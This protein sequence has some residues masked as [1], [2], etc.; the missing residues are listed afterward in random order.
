MPPLSRPRRLLARISASSFMRGISKITATPASSSVRK[1]PLDPDQEQQ[2]I[3]TIK[4]VNAARLCRQ[5]HFL[6]GVSEIIK[7]ELSQRICSFWKSQFSPRRIC[8]A[9]VAEEIPHTP[10]TTPVRRHAGRAAQFHREPRRA[11][12]RRLEAEEIGWFIAPARRGRPGFDLDSRPSRSKPSATGSP[13]QAGLRHGHPF[14]ELNRVMDLGF[15]RL[16][17]GDTGYL[18]ANLEPSLIQTNRH[19]VDRTADRPGWSE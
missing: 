8:A 1:K 9:L 5:A 11:A 4:D 16:P 19:L 14:N 12:L 2:I 7:P 13:R 10:P 3:A 17:W 18:P 15:K 6:A